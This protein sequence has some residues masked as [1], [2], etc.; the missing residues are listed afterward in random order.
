MRSSSVSKPSR[1]SGSCQL[2]AASL[3]GVAGVVVSCLAAGWAMATSLVG[4]IYRPARPTSESTRLGR[5]FMKRGG[6]R[7]DDRLV[8][9]HRLA[10]AAAS[11]FEY[12]PETVLPCWGAGARK[13]STEGFKSRTAED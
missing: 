12:W 1:S 5:A 6:W 7:A 11:R 10:D 8:H 2:N 3:I 9:I 4:P 13:I